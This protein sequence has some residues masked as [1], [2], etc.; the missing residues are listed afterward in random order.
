MELNYKGNYSF[1][2]GIQAFNNGL[3]GNND[4]I[5]VLKPT[6]TWQK[7]YVDLNLA[8]ALEPTSTYFKVYM[9]GVLDLTV[10]SSAAIY[11][12]NIKVIRNG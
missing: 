12:D 5:V 11:F 6:G 3:P 8:S 9:Y 10:Q 4:D 1:T 2:V 7:I